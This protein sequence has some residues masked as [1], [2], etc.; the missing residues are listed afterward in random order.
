MAIFKS[1]HPIMVFYIHHSKNDINERC[2]FIE[3][4]ALNKA[5]IKNHY[6]LPHIDDL[7]DQ[8]YGDKFFTKLVLTIIYHQ[9]RMVSYNTWNMIFKMKYNLYESLV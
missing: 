1:T 6:P 4:H 7:L 8:L 2:L 3:Y 9:V 5:T